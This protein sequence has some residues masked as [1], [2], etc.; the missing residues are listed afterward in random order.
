MK[1]WLK[2][3]RSVVLAGL[4]IGLT[5]FVAVSAVGF[6]VKLSIQLLS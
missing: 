4:L 1:N 2:A 3:I 6:G 5:V